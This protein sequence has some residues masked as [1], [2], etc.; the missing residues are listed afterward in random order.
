MNGTPAPTDLDEV[1]KAK[2]EAE[3][4]A[5]KRRENEV[6]DFQWVMS[7]ARGRRLV[8]RLMREAGVFHSSLSD[9]A[10]ELAANE[11]R[12]RQGLLLL[13]EVMKVCPQHWISMI[14]DQTSR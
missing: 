9:N 6:A 14:K 11:G 1:A 13:D 5:R 10:L 2:E 4:E 12:R 3:L 7:D 8:W